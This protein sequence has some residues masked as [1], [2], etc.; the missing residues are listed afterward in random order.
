M[1]I[2]DHGVSP[3][4]RVSY[5]V[6]TAFR[7]EAHRRAR[8]IIGMILDGKPRDVV[9]VAIS[10]LLASCNLRQIGP[11]SAENAL[12]AQ[13]RREANT[14]ITSP[15]PVP[16]EVVA[17]AVLSTRTA[18]PG[19]SVVIPPAVINGT[20]AA[21]MEAPSTPPTIYSETDFTADPVSRLVRPRPL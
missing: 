17:A 11:A 20:Y 2:I 5:Y 19:H 9:A 13:A 12:L 7:P 14:G 10:A 18:V 16:T 8:A 6:P 15:V 4:D 3:S 1:A 21:E